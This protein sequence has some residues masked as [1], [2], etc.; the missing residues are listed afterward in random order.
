MKVLVFGIGGVGGLVGGAL[1]R[2][3]A[4]TYFYA[5]NATKKAIE[6][7][8]LVL[9]S[10]KFGNQVVHP[11]MVSDDAVAL[12]PMDVIFVACKGDKLE[13][14]CKAIAPMVTPQTV[15]IP[16]LNGITVSNNMAPHLPPC[17]LADGTIRVFSHIEA[18]GHIVQDGGMCDI[19]FGLQNGKN[20]A[21]FE[22]IAAL[23]TKVGIKTIVV[24]DIV[25][26]SWQKFAITGTMSAIL[27]YYD[28]NTGYV[29]EQPD[30]DTIIPAAYR[31]VQAVAKAC[32]V[33]L[34][35]SFIESLTKSFYKMPADTISSL[36]RD[37]LAGKSAADTELYGLVGYLVDKGREVNVATPIF[38]KAYNRF[39]NK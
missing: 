12:G 7:N 8:G 19:S 13:V 16:L 18:P 31:E 14:A 11:K 23:L 32:G 22:D 9:D 24:E 3:H 29:L 20:P 38:E 6:E 36:Y 25:V 34:S 37:L 27:C 2:V 35:D 5:R 4:D 28:G 26:R 1:A 30:C 10:I 33:V 17:I 15:V 21:V 39:L